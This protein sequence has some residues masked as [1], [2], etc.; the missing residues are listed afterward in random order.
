MASTSSLAIAV[1]IFTAP[2]E[3]FGPL[4]DQPRA[5]FPILLLI[6]GYS[7]VSF[8][9]MYAVDL[10][11]FIDAQMQL[12]GGEL[13]DA[14]REQ[15]AERVSSVSPAFYGAFGAVATSAFVLLVMFL[16]ALYYTGVSFVTHDGVR[17]KQWFALV[18]WCTLPTVLGIVAQLVNIL[19]TDAR[20]MAQDEINPLSFGSLLSIDRAGASVMQRI[21]LGMD[22]TTIWGVVLTVLGYQAWTKSALVKTVAIV[23]GPLMLIIAIGT[24][25]T[26]T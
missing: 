5:L 21:L 17:L 20:F 25:L 14:Q 12:G 2:N 8:T 23:L 4:K 19:A 6:V 1:N 10:P 18:A 16:S 9:Y 11:W 3:A 22:P 26:L 15:A 24:L 7:M 13:T